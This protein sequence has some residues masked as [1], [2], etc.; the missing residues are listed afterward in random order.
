MPELQS[1]CQDTNS[2]SLSKLKAFNCEI[3]LDLSGDKISRMPGQ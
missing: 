2:G 3:Y 1:N